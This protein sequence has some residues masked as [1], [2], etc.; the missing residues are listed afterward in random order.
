MVQ[1]VS[2]DA[3]IVCGCRKSSGTLDSANT[4]GAKRTRVWVL[5][6]STRAALRPELT[7]SLAVLSTQ[8][9]GYGRLIRVWE[10]ITPHHVGRQIGPDSG[11]GAF[12]VVSDARHNFKRK[13]KSQC[14]AG[15]R[16]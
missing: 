5:D 3:A 7:K 16:K 6:D 4:N 9:C 1:G 11:W 2:S 14:V 10:T 15:K 12:A 13:G 8:L